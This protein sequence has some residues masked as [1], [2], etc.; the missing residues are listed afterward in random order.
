MRWLFAAK[1]SPQTPSAFVSHDRVTAFV[2]ER[3]QLGQDMRVINR[4]R[5]RGYAIGI[6]DP[7]LG[8]PAGTCR[9]KERA[10]VVC[11][12]LVY[13]DRP[14]CCW[15]WFRADLLG[16]RPEPRIDLEHVDYQR[17]KLASANRVS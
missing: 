10:S 17:P 5:C 7:Q 3:D 11:A 15:L 2:P 14:H 4:A 16:H 12:L 6:V 1:Y 8:A 9:R 13:P